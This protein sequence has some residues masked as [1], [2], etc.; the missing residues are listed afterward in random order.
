MPSWFLTYSSGK[1]GISFPGENDTPLFLSDVIVS[2]YDVPRGTL[3]GIKH[4]GNQVS[5][6][7]FGH[8]TTHDIEEDGVIN[9]YIAIADSSCPCVLFKIDKAW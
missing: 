6:S 1:H 2:Q 8:I 4:V 9:K 7:T 3:P 5:K